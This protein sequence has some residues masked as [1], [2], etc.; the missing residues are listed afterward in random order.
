[1]LY[2]EQPAGVGFSYCKGV[3]DCAF[4]DHTSAEDNLASVLAWYQKFPEFQANELYI[5]GESYAGIYVPYLAYY[6]DQH[7]TEFAADETVF[8]PNLK[9]FMVGNG[10]TNWDYDTTNAY[11]DMAY[12]HS[13]YE[14]ELYEQMQAL[15]CDYN[16]PYMTRTTPECFALLEQFDSLV[17]NVNVYDI[18]GVC[19]GSFPYPS[20]QGVT[21]AGVGKNTYYS[22]AYYTPWL[23]HSQKSDSHHLRVLPPCVWGN[24]LQEW[25]NKWEVRSKLNIPQE[26]QAWSLCSNIAYVIEPQGSQWI[27][28]ELKGKYRMLFYS[29]DIDGAVPTIGS[30][31]WI[32]TLEWKTT[33][34]WR[35]YMV[36]DQV[37]GYVEAY[38]GNL[39]FGTVHGAGHM[40]P[41]VKREET[42]Y[43]VFNWLYERKI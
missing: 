10:V 35:P 22:A 19:Y 14:P 9:G 7:N 18:F 43:L 32:S 29:G 17:A 36:N 31:K 26:I 11:V 34:S 30:Q 8:K 37:A 13:L 24:P 20:L 21:D 16:G 12:W 41:Q 42:Y 6:I 33:E 39:T 15:Q 2:I 1:M 23:N 3:K 4:N 5:S 28:E 27:Y 38:D 25:L 40:A